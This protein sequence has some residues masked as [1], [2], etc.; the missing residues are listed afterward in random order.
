MTLHSPATR[1]RQAAARDLTLFGLRSSIIALAV[2]FI[3]LALVLKNKWVLAGI[4]AWE[5]L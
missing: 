2:V 4:L 5:V 1:L 3:V